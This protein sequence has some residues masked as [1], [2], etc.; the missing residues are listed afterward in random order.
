MNKDNIV[1]RGYREGDEAPLAR[2]LFDNFP[3]SP[4]ND[5]TD[6]IRQTWLW[7]FKNRDSV[8]P[9][10]I[11]AEIDSRIVAQYAVMKR[12]MNFNGAVAGGAISTATV[13]ARKYRG[14]GLF[15]KL[16]QTLYDD[17]EKEDCQLVF[18]FPNGQSIS[19]FITRLGWFEVAPFPLH[20]KIL[21]VTP[22]L[23]RYLGKGLHSELA[24]GLG[25]SFLRTVSGSR[26]KKR[27]RY[28]FE[29]V[30]S[31]DMLP[32]DTDFLW[33]ESS[34]SGGIA[35]LRSRSYLEWRYF[36]KPSFEYKITTVL[37]EGAL[38][39]LFVTCMSEKFGIRIMYVMEF[40][41]RG[42]SQDVHEAMIDNLDQMAVSLGAHCISILLI[43]TYP[44]Y[45]HFRKSGFNR[46]P[47][48][49]FPQDI[50]FGAK[51]LAGHENEAYIR[52]YRNWYVSWG[53]LDA[54]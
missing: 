39:G 22:F 44:H 30:L 6:L 49:L 24:A 17:L 38:L 37:L 3:N 9:P 11:L 5:R 35:V 48:K 16:A 27:T 21:D 14:K 15:V 32:G 19:G 33:K 50:Y 29:T 2:L 45:G 28:T 40:V 52:D 13:T 23:C 34:V 43:P 1:L 26:R 7:Q 51:V 25:N 8:V 54:V 36:Y 10:V 31:P 4:E 20:L 18:G 12:P 47:K 41:A 42:D 53:D 46:V